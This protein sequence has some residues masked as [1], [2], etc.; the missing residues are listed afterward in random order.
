MEPKVQMCSLL[1]EAG[2]LLIWDDTTKGLN[3]DYLTKTR[4]LAT[5]QLKKK[6]ATS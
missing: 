4:H 3:L 5:F 2:S 1:V 6:H